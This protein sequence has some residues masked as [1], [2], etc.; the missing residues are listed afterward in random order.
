MIFLHVFLVKKFSLKSD[1][2]TKSV[3]KI[4]LNTLFFFKNTYGAKNNF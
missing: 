4:L 2:S 1:F 3:F